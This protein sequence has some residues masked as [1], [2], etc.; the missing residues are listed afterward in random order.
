MVFV[1]LCELKEICR[2]IRHFCNVIETY[3]SQRK[4]RS[5][6]ARTLLSTHSGK[7]HDQNPVHPST[8]GTRTLERPLLTRPLGL[9]PYPLLPHFSTRFLISLDGCDKT[10]FESTLP[11]KDHL[12]TPTSILWSYHHPTHESIP[13]LLSGPSPQV[14]KVTGSLR[15]SL[16]WEGGAE[17][18]V[19]EKPTEIIIF[20]EAVWVRKIKRC[21]NVDHK[22][23]GCY[24]KGTLDGWRPKK[25]LPSRPQ[26]KYFRRTSKRRDTGVARDLLS[27]SGLTEYKIRDGRIECDICLWLSSVSWL[28]LRSRFSI[29]KISKKFDNPL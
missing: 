9:P 12:P 15:R 10:D 5:S 29:S 3:V 8:D 25:E 24:R 21:V 26:W 1:F 17:W 4:W 20:K 27:E 14:E 28:D 16:C 18:F 11:F 23:G 13:L 22:K 19:C 2:L 6:G 7:S